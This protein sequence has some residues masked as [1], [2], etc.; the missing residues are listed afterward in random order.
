MQNTKEHVR[1]GTNRGGC[2]GAAK[3]REDIFTVPA[4]PIPQS[5]KPILY[6][7]AVP[8][9]PNTAIKI[10]PYNHVNRVLDKYVPSDPNLASSYK[11]LQ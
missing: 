5:S 4:S 6:N 2:G 11:Y 10:K 9:L 8:S 1:R 7:I 3:G